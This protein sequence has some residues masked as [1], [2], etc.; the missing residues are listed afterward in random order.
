MKEYLENGLDKLDQGAISEG[1]AQLVAVLAEGASPSDA[2]TEELKRRA[3]T[4]LA[5]IRAGLAMETGTEWLD[6][7][8]NQLT[9]SSVSRRADRTA[10]IRA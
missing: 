8:K 4:E 3:E 1:I 5:K 10:S 7:N 9:A 2:A 6:A